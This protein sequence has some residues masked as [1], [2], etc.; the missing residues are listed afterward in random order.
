MRTHDAPIQRV[1]H[2]RLVG[3]EAL[4]VAG[5][6]SHVHGSEAHGLDGA[7]R[8]VRR[9]R[10]SRVHVHSHA[11]VHLGFLGHLGAQ[12]PRPHDAAGGPQ[13]RARRARLATRDDRY[14]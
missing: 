10:Q 12:R 4:V 6:H 13:R 5:R 3:S 2:A 14:R 8:D 9:A 7:D 11:R 1:L